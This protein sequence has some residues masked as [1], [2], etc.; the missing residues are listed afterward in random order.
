MKKV[1]QTLVDNKRGN[2]MQAA[3]ASLLE[4]ELEQVP[5]FIEAGE[6]WGKIWFGFWKDQGLEDYPVEISKDVHDTTLLKRVAEF[7][8]GFNGYFYATVP[9]QTFEDTTH[10]VIVDKN[11][12]VVHDPNPNQK[13]LELNPEDVLS[14][15]VTKNMIIGKTGKIFTREEWDNA[16]REEQ[17]AN[18]YKMNDHKK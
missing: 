10:A 16:S 8:G 1:Y 3:V 5:N 14:I 6:E 15:L 7:D 11:L 13:A 12:K 2:C 17:A 9:S 4:L 18:T